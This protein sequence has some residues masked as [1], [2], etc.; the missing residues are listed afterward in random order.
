MPCLV[1]A[2]SRRAMIEGSTLIGIAQS[3]ARL[4]HREETVVDWLLIGGDVAIILSF[5]LGGVSF[6][7]VA[8]NPLW[9]GVRIALPFL[10]GY[11]AL[12]ALT[13][14]LRWRRPAWHFAGRSLAAW[15]LGMS[16][17]FGLRSLILATPPSP[18]FVKIALIYTATLFCLWRTIFWLWRRFRPTHP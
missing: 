11:L 10:L 18:I 9:S 6:H 14:A 8:G 1:W 2:C 15:M 5:A 3:R 4:G 13:G 7:Q 12:A 17:G 16:V